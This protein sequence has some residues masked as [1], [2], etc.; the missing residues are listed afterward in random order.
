VESIGAQISN[1]Q[2]IGK[3]FELR[4]MIT[5]LDMNKEWCERFTTHPCKAEIFCIE[6]SKL[7]QL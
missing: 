6:Y 5:M 7:K 2:K 1:F 3:K 4:N